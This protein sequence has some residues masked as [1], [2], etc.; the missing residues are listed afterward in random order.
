MKKYI[1]FYDDGGC[2]AISLFENN[3]MTK[4]WRTYFFENNNNNLYPDYGRDV[5]GKS[6]DF[7]SNVYVSC[8]ADIREISEEEAF[9][10]LL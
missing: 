8:K 3:I 4:R 6:L 2:H 7:Y 1:A 10:L 9:G 5:L